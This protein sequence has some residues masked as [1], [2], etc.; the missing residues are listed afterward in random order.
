MDFI[1]FDGLSLGGLHVIVFLEI[2][3]HPNP[4]PSTMGAQFAN[5][6]RIKRYPTGSFIIAA[7]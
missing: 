7:D 6:S 1:V 4:A 3:T 5:V 2:K